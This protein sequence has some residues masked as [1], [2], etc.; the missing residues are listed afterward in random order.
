MGFAPDLGAR[1]RVAVS[2]SCSHKH[3]PPQAVDH[4]KRLPRGFSV[5]DKLLKAKINLLRKIR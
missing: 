3:G 2:W 5:L 1:E 4:V